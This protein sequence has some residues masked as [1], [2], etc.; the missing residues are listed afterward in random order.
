MLDHRMFLTEGDDVIA[1]LARRNVD[2][3]L[4]R[5]LRELADRRRTELQRAESLRHELNQASAAVQEKARSGD[6]QAADATREKLRALKTDIKAIEAQQAATEAALEALLLRVPNL[7]DTSVPDGTNESANRVERVVGTPR[8]FD[9]EARPHWEVAEKL[10]I[11]DFERASKVSGP[12]FAIYRGAGARLERAIITFMLDLAREHGYTEIIP[13][14]LVRPE[15]MVGSGQYPKFEGESFETQDRELVLIPTAE[16]PLVNMHRDEILDESQ[17]P[18]RYVA[19]T[20]CFR[21]E[22]GAAGKDTRGLI[23][24]HQFNKVELVAYT[25]PEESAREHERLTGNAEEVLKRLELP[26]RVVSLCT[27]DLGFAAA[28]T[29]D[30]EVWLPGQNT[31]REISSCS[32]CADFQARRARVRYR[33]TSEG[34]KGKPRLVHMLNG[35]G[36]AVGR[37]FLAVL[38]NGQQQDGSVDLPKALAHYLG[39]ARRIAADGTLTAGV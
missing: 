21:R 3:K 16:V 39:G 24:Q 30:L 32:N 14:F 37:T 17:L 15:S 34:P 38:E 26:Y 9:F 20:P 12:R 2:E 33:P 19:Y 11:V 13:P 18:M 1:K 8:H 6:K 4:V 27:G 25:T 36:L 22:A 35:S 7:P 28:K 23:R 29:Y 10:G 5:E 31:Y